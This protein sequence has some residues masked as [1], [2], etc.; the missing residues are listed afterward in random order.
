M[1]ETIKGE[2]WQQWAERAFEFEDCEECGHGIEG[3]RPAVVMGNW[4]AV[5]TGALACGHTKHEFCGITDALMG[6]CLACTKGE[7]DRLRTI[8]SYVVRTLN[9][10]LRHAPTPDDILS[11]RE[12]LRG[13]AINDSG[14]DIDGGNE[15]DPRY[16]GGV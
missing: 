1:S 10:W 12:W 5:C 3:H 11:L 4:F 13:P 15:D 14:P 16:H 7:R 2:T 9:D 6:D 8:P